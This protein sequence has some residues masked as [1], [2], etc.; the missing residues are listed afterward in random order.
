[1]VEGTVFA[2]QPTIHAFADT[3]L[4]TRWVVAASN[5]FVYEQ[6]LRNR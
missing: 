6:R 2:G 3:G 4:F 1:M 5:D